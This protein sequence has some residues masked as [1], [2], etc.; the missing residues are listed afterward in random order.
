VT[1]FANIANFGKGEY[2]QGC[3]TL[4]PNGSVPMLCLVAIVMYCYQTDAE[5]CGLT[6]CMCLYEA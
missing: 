2:A 1:A 5:L 3:V 4:L 6:L